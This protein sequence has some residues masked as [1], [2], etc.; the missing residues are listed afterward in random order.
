MPVGAQALVPIGACGRV[1]ARICLRSSGAR[2][3]PEPCCPLVAEPWC[4]LVPVVESVPGFA[5]VSQVPAWCQ[6]LVPIDA[7]IYVWD[8]RWYNCLIF[9]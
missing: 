5:S 4:P 3:V 7:Q 6:A 1:R 2:L 8:R 9:V